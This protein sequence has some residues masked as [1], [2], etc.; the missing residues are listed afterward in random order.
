MLSLALLIFCFDN[1]LQS[2]RG[3]KLPTTLQYLG[4]QT[5]TKSSRILFVIVSMNDPWSRKANKYILI[6]LLSTQSLSA[7]YSMTIL[8]KSG[9]PD[10]R[11]WHS[12]ERTLSL[13]RIEYGM[14]FYHPIRVRRQRLFSRLEISPHHIPQMNL[15]F[16]IYYTKVEIENAVCR[17]YLDTDKQHS[18]YDSSLPHALIESI[19]FYSDSLLSYSPTSCL[20]S[21][22]NPLCP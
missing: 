9:C 3:L 6:D 17:F 11:C 7:T 22:S 14:D 15:A 5:C 1:N 4:E 2:P 8:A 20:N 16:L 12:S 19:Q 10:K 21:L 13:H 18:N